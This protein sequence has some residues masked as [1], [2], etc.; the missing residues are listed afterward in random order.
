[1]ADENK[2]NRINKLTAYLAVIGAVTAGVFC[3]AVPIVP[4]LG[5]VAALGLMVVRPHK[6]AD[7]IA[8]LA[9]QSG[10]L[11][12]D[13]F[14]HAREDVSRGKSFLL[15]R[16]L[17]RKQ[18]KAAKQAALPP[19]LPVEEKPG[20]LAATPAPQPG[21]NKSATRVVDDAPIPLAEPTPKPQPPAPPKA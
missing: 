14:S 9:N 12:K 3:L 8:K 19:K 20:N 18:K 4:V 10:Q 17:A 5:S 13:A 11:A 1:M 21:F 2:P 7:G 16:H 15:G 6:T